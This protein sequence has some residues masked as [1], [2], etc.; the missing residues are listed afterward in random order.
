[1]NHRALIRQLSTNKLVPMLLCLQVSHWSH[2]Q[3]SSQ[4]NHLFHSPHTN[5]LPPSTTTIKHATTLPNPSGFTCCLVLRSIPYLVKD[6]NKRPNHTPSNTLAKTPHKNHPNKPTTPTT[7]SYTKRIASMN[8]QHAISPR[9]PKH[10]G[11][12][13]HTHTHTHS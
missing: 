5:R 9:L 2:H 11:R 12:H 3:T 1:M 7:D 10:G 4:P 6:A 8:K 13:A